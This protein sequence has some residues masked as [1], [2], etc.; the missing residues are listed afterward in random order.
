MKKAELHWGRPQDVPTT[1]AEV[2]ATAAEKWMADN[3]R[4]AD[5]CICLVASDDDDRAGLGTA[6]VIA[7][8]ELDALVHI[9]A[10][11]ADHL[12]AVA[13]TLGLSRHDVGRLFCEGAE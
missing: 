1:A 7:A 6:G 3:G 11:L 4:S 5:Y 12:A 10:A 9:Y 13:A 8:S 2:G